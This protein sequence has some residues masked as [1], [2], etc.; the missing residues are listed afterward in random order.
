MNNYE[1]QFKN[2]QS[3]GQNNNFILLDRAI[4]SDI[5]QKGKIRIDALNGYFG[6]EY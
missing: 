2:L 1:L 6:I 4:G 5:R 3:D